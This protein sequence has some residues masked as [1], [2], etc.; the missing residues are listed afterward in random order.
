MS[1]G[2]VEAI[3]GSNGIEKPLD[4][5]EYVWVQW[6]D[7]PRYIWLAFG[8]DGRLVEGNFDSVQGQVAVRSDHEGMVEL[9]LRAVD[10]WPYEDNYL[11][12]PA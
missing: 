8:R 10:W 5:A 4:K 6:R 12:F 1:R 7:G 9:L 11:V 3:F 2:R